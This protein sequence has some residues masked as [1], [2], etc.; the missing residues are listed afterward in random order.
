MEIWNDPISFSRQRELCRNIK[1]NPDLAVSLEGD[2]IVELPWNLGVSFFNVPKLR[3][4]NTD[5]MKFI[6]SHAENPEVKDRN[7]GN[8]GAYLEFYESTTR[9]LNFIFNVKPYLKEDKHFKTHPTSTPLA[10]TIYCLL[11]S[12]RRKYKICHFWYLSLHTF[13]SL[14]S[15]CASRS[16]NRILSH[17][18]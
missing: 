11:L 12:S 17:S 4:T 18:T 5:F 10:L 6:E 2:E 9:F 3:Q 13:E 7:L 14:H 8:Q 1:E 16:M 15:S